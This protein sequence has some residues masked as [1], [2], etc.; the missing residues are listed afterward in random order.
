MCRRTGHE[1]GGVRDDSSEPGISGMDDRHAPE[2]LEAMLAS[3]SR[4]RAEGR[5]VVLDSTCAGDRT[6]HTGA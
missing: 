5:D 6:G 4:L 1:S 2:D 3:L